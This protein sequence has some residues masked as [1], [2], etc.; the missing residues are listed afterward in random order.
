MAYT[1]A[2]MLVLLDWFHMMH[3]NSEAMPATYC[4][5]DPED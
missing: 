5:N 1:V 3:F 2:T 4:D